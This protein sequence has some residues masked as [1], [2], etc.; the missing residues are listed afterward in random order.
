MNFKKIL[1]LASADLRMAPGS[2]MLSILNQM[3]TSKIDGH[4]RIYVAFFGAKK[5]IIEF[6]IPVAGNDVMSSDNNLF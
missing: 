2:A 6:S 4:F 1:Q 5:E 3:I